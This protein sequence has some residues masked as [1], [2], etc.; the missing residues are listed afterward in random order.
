[1]RLDAAPDAMP[2][3]FAY[4][5]TLKVTLEDGV[6]E[7]K[8]ADFP[9]HPSKHTVRSVERAQGLC[10]GLS[11]KSREFVEDSAGLQAF[12]NCHQTDTGSISRSTLWW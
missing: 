12:A 1:V 8:P 11:G 7:R 4:R 6:L 5:V 3:D 10:N 9:G 2:R